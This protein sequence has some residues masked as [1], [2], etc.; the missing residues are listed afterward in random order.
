MRFASA[1]S[2]REDVGEAA[3]QLITSLRDQLRSEVDLVL[4][5]LTYHYRDSA[6]YLTERINSELSPKVLLGCTCEGV[7]SGGQEIEREPAI[8]AMAASL[9]GIDIKPFH[10]SI[11]HWEELFNSE[12]PAELQSLIGS[13]HPKTRAYVLLGDP[14]TTP[15]AELLFVLD[16]LSPNI[17]KVGGM[18]SGANQAGQN[19]LLLNDSIHREGVVG[20][21][22]AGDFDVD[23]VVSQGCRPIGETLLVTKAEGNLIETLGGKLALKV[24]QNI[25]NSISEEEKELV[26]NGLF[27]GVVINEYQS[28]FARGDFLVRSVL[29]ADPT[30]GAIA[31]SDAVRAGQTV[32][33]HVRDADTADEDL[34][35]LMKTSGQHEIAPRGGL[36]FTCNG[37]GVR[38]FDMPNHDVRTVLE[39]VPETPVAGFFCNGEFGPVGGKTFIHG[40]TASVLLFRPRE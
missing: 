33:F 29:G 16:T 14:Y 8:S 21:R 7:I 18:A 40:H 1:I 6:D 5:F 34:R 35:I 27:F 38:M 25:L 2:R 3:D 20:I 9:T 30:R 10:L 13:E 37:R 17:P 4:L 22:L 15:V 24:T 11:E 32:R 31:V 39:A 12:N 28:E 26:K 23:C 36:I 19:Q